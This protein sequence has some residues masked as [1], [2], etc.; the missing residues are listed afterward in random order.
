[1][2]IEGREY[3]SARRAA[4]I[5][6]YSNDY[7]GQLCRNKK[8]AARMIGRSWFVDQASFIE[9]THSVSHELAPEGVKI[10]V[11]DVPATRIEPE[12]VV[13]E[14]VSKMPTVAPRKKFSHATRIFDHSSKGHYD[15]SSKNWDVVYSADDRPLLPVIDKGTKTISL[16]QRPVIHDAGEAARVIKSKTRKAVSQFH[17]VL[18]LIVIG[19]ISLSLLSF[20][21][22][23]KKLPA[24]FGTASMNASVADGIESAAR[25]TGLWLNGSRLGIVASIK[26]IFGASSTDT[27][28]ELGNE[29]VLVRNDIPFAPWPTSAVLPSPSLLPSPSSSSSHSSSAPSPVGIQPTS[30]FQTLQPPTLSTAPVRIVETTTYVNSVDQSVYERL[31]LIERDLLSSRSRATPQADAIVR[32][33]NSSG[34]GSSGGSGT[35]TS[36]DASGGS[37][38]LSF[39]GGPL[40]TSGTLTLGGTLLETS[41]GTGQSSYTT[42]DILYASSADTLSKLAVGSSGQVLKISGGVP[43]WGTDIAGSG[44][45]SAFATSSDDLSIH[46][47]DTTDVLVLGG[48]ATTTT[49]NIFE[50]IGNTKFGGDVAVTGTLNPVTSGGSNIGTFD[51]GFNTIRARNF[52]IE[53]GAGTNGFDL[54]QSTGLTLGAGARLGFTVGSVEGL[55]ITDAALMRKGSF[56]LEVNSG[57]SGNYADL[58]VRSLIT[59]QNL[60][61]GTTSPYTKLSVAGGAH[62]G[63]DLI[64]TGT[65]T[66]SDLSDGLVKS[67]NGVLSNAVAGSDYLTPSDI[68]AYPFPSNAT[69]TLISFNGGLSAQGTSTFAENVVIGTSTIYASGASFAGGSHLVQGGGTGEIVAT[70][71]SKA[72][73]SLVTLGEGFSRINAI[74]P[75]STAS[76]YVTTNTGLSSIIASGNGAFAQG[77]SGFSGGTIEA[78]GIGSLAVGYAQTRGIVSSGTGSFAGGRGFLGTTTASGA[79]SFAFGEG[80]TASG[81]FSTAFGTNFTNS[82]ANSFM[83]GYSST[84]TLTVNSTSV[85]IGTTSPYAKLSVAGGAHIGGDLTAT[86]TITFSGLSNGLVKSTNGVLSNAVAGSDY[87][88]SSDVFAYPFAVTGNATSTLTQFNGGL[89]SYASTTVGDGTQVGGLTISGG[90]TT[91]GNAYVAGTLASASTIYGHAYRFDSTHG[92]GATGT[93]FD[94]SPTSGIYFVSNGTQ[95]ALVQRSSNREFHLDATTWLNWASSGVGAADVG[96][97]RNAAGVL[98]LSVGANAGDIATGGIGNARD[99]I[100]RNLMVGSTSPFARLSITAT[101]SA[102]TI[103]L[104]AIQTPTPN[105]VSTSTVFIVDA[106]GNVGIGTTSPG[107]RLSVAG[108]VLANNIIGSYFTSTSTTATTTLAGALAVGTVPTTGT[109]G[110]S[111]FEIYGNASGAEFKGLNIYNKA[112]QAVGSAASLLL[113]TASNAA[114]GSGAVAKIQAVTANATPGTRQTDLAFY[115][116][117]QSA[118]HLE[119]MRITGGGNVG[120][121]TTTPN[122]KLFIS[123]AV[124]P[125][126]TLSNSVVNSANSGTINFSEVGYLMDGTD[127]SARGFSVVHDGVNNKLNFNG[128]SGT[129]IDP[130]LTLVRVSGSGAVGIGTTTPTAKLTVASSGTGYNAAPMVAIYGSVQSGT[131]FIDNVSNTITR[132]TV[133]IGGNGS[134]LD[135]LLNVYQGNNNS[136][137]M[138]T[139]G[140]NVGIGTTTPGDKLQITAPVS[141][142]AAQLGLRVTDSSAQTAGVGGGI[143]FGLKY[144]SGGTYVTT[145]GIKA[146]KENSTDGNYATALTFYTTPN[147]GVAFS[148]R[149]MDLLSSGNVGIGTTSP[150][151]KLSVAGQSVAEYFTSTSSTAINTFPLLTATTATTTNLAVTSITSSLLKTN[152]LGQ[153]TAAVAGTDYLTSSNVAAYPFGLTGNATSTLTQFN[154]GLTSYASSTIGSGT[155]AGGLTISGGATTT[156]TAY[157]ADSITMATGTLSLIGGNFAASSPHKGLISLKYSDSSNTGYLGLMQQSWN[158]L[159]IW[160]PGKALSTSPTMAFGATSISISQPINELANAIR[161]NPRGDVSQGVLV[162]SGGNIPTFDIKGASGQLQPLLRFASSSSDVLTVVGSDGSIGIGTTSPYA[163]LSV[164]MAS[165]TPSFVVAAAGSSTPSLYVGSANANGYVGVG[166]AAPSTVFHVAG[167]PATATGPIAIFQNTASQVA[168]IKLQGTDRSVTINGQVNTLDVSGA[169]RSSKDAAGS[170][171][172][173]YL[174]V[175]GNAA[176]SYGSLGVDSSLNIVLTQSQAANILLSGGNVGIG[177]TSPYAKLSVAGDIVGG[178]FVA[179]TTATSTFAGGLN[180]A[181]LNVTGIT[182]TSTFASGIDLAAGCFSIGGTCI[183][184][185]SGS[186]QWTTAGSDIYYTTGNVGIG[187]TTPYAK[188]SVVGEVVSSNFTATSTTA[189]STF[190]GGLYA[191]GVSI[192]DNIQLGNLSFDDDAGAVAWA[193]LPI[194]GAASSTVESY[195]AAI[196]DSPILTIYGLADNAGGV[197]TAYTGVGVATTSPWRKLSVAGTVGFDGLSIAAASGDALCLSAN[198]EVVVNS[199]AQTCTVSSLRFKQNVETLGAAMNTLNQLRPVTFQYKGTNENHLGFI[200][201]E[202]NVLE[203]RLVFYD[204]NADG[205]DATSTP[206]GVRY[207]EMTAL[208]VKAV[209]EQQ[210]QIDMLRGASTTTATSSNS[211]VAQI[212]KSVTDFI[213]SAGE[214]V[215]SKLT[216]TTIYAGDVNADK[217]TTKTLCVDDLCISKDQ[218]RAL[219]MNAGVSGSDGENSDTPATSTMTT[220]TSSATSTATSTGPTVTLNGSDLISIE[221]GTSFNDPGAVGKDGTG[222]V[223]VVNITGDLNTGVRGTYHLVY[224]VTDLANVTA[225]TTRTVIVTPVTISIEDNP[226]DIGEETATSTQDIATSTSSTSVPDTIV[227]SPAT[228]PVDTDMGTSTIQTGE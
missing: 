45:S 210:I 70:N 59:S 62:I 10:A 28:P 220:T 19:F 8:I 197:N 158:M 180:V 41:G 194:V 199:G 168:S 61:I 191:S 82:T 90:A 128:V 48:S 152:A 30:V 141:F 189:T 23:S 127:S 108:D 71:S 227:S 92:T 106:Y 81:S 148:T 120:I 113:T 185:S 26:K 206:R 32:L 91:T 54:S 221:E 218:F 171:N 102:T 208:I 149:V 153:L 190:A 56:A 166:T 217:V 165:T 4:E 52:R 40:T 86:G 156:G 51:Q 44:G 22:V 187:T 24:T 68:F 202:V 85:G 12:K 5:G 46:P 97:K 105:N 103:P 177:T 167:A 63:G 157:F 29:T 9:Y 17:L 192:F 213:Q 123:D 75:G 77:F 203:P 11:Q 112:A 145:A 88:T 201:E 144:N 150:Y 184:G 118:G 117:L 76:G 33:I 73:G 93:G 116:D 196:D 204:K 181:Y 49:G 172:G 114:A 178:R 132:A 143:G 3:I 212:S 216:A 159:G 64:A 173:A 16:Q 133:N 69:S 205:T 14:L 109:Y 38:G 142:G 42:G 138:V 87:L 214:W 130:L 200:A 7:I 198:K 211:L 94:F 162:T 66:F 2:K 223:L 107:Q 110:L 146:N 60:G 13:A 140:G 126:L 99:L 137:F 15:G 155:Q 154:G 176:T 80:V 219:I 174:M 122:A 84:P 226:P 98:E 131:T 115:T 74:G 215:I 89:T 135:P 37:T 20:A 222:N 43:V 50:V 79:A 169:L 170:T 36:I 67:T 225:S 160:G 57:S 18:P 209:Q 182:A 104:F 119:R 6:K 188:L 96:L 207:E 151:A 136:R 175:N 111:P 224:S 195:T 228:E 34:G 53:S 27:D 186:S 125:T 163:K 121:G 129:V 58:Y 78:S 193:N 1:M 134:D 83:V 124:A 95:L 55:T 35:L 72:F 183:G 179:T 100:L 164:G 147:S 31:S 47:A 39:S 25:S 21:F 139:S 65:V 161:L 101:S